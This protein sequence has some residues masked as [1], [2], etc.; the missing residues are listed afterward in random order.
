M[1]A[2]QSSISGRKESKHNR[3]ARL[4]VRSIATF[5]A[6]AAVC[7]SLYY[8]TKVTGNLRNASATDAYYS[9]YAYNKYIGSHFSEIQIYPQ[10]F[11]ILQQKQQKQKPQLPFELDSSNPSSWNDHDRS[12][13][14]DKFRRHNR[15]SVY[16]LLLLPE[17]NSTEISSHKSDTVLQWGDYFAYIH[18]HGRKRHRQGLYEYHDMEGTEF[19]DEAE[20]IAYRENPVVLEACWGNTPDQPQKPRVIEEHNICHAFKNAKQIANFQ[21]PHVLI[22]HLNENWGT[23]SSEVLD[24]TADWGDIV[25]NMFKKD[26]S[27]FD[28]DPVE[29]KELYLD[30]PNTLAVFTTT[31]QSIFDHPKV[32]S[33]PIGVGNSRN[34]GNEFLTVLKKQKELFKVRPS[35]DPR[36]KLLMIN[37]SPS[38]T[39]L[40]QMNAIIRNFRKAN[41]TV[42]NTF[43]DSDSRSAYYAEM[44]GSKFILCPSGLG[45]D[46]YRVWE[47]IAMGAIPVIER[48]KYRYQTMT[49][50]PDSGK[51][52][53][54]LRTLKKGEDGTKV[55]DSSRNDMDVNK[56]MRKHN[57]SLGVIEYYD[58]WQKT[59]DD[60][61]VLWIDGTF[62][63]RPSKGNKPSEKKYLT[64]ELLEREYDALA[65]KMETFRYE[66]LTS[67][68]WIRFIESFLLLKDPSEAHK[69]VDAQISFDSHEEQHTWQTAME[70][71]PST[72]NNHTVVASEKRSQG[73]TDKGLPSDE[74]ESPSGSLPGISPYL[75]GEYQL[76]TLSW[77]TLLELKILGIALMA[78]A[79]KMYQNN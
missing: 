69:G 27:G 50:P 59:L 7:S 14:H 57:A 37:S 65:A 25:S 68:Y 5:L 28:C 78:T 43:V 2:T 3:T 33:I 47:A 73:Q 6:A 61:P 30:S 60:L 31:H 41:L 52:S 10:D 63:D 35:S 56:K 62:G 79:V 48:Y 71:L 77:V 40:P 66:K 22:T 67:I 29:L 46:T 17:D 39:R 53:E 13:M 70:N 54:I 45:W 32:H 58:G 12:Q 49:Y 74:D 19:E 26:N 44:S 55:G 36:P 72:F 75:F 42:Q 16:S 11:Q 15:D 38:P 20:S 64:P 4:G 9:T 34:H 8:D 24:R 51:R 1:T 21:T 76:W 18:E 23:L